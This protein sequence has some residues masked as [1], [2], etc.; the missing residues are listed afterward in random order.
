MYLSLYSYPSL[1]SFCVADLKTKIQREERK[2]RWWFTT[3]RS[4]QTYRV[5]THAD[6]MPAGTQTARTSIGTTVDQH[7]SN[8]ATC[9]IPPLPPATAEMG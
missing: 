1:Y 8:R 9:A 7:K 5:I 2:N 6:I 4:S 3:S